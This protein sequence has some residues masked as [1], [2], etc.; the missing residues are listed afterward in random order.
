MDKF[1]LYRS[2]F[3]SFK[4]LCAKGDQPCSFCTYCK[5]YGV[6][7][8]LMPKVL[9]GDFQKIA[10]LPGYR[11]IPAKRPGGIGRLCIRI[12]EDFK[13]LCADGRQPGTFKSYHEGFGVSRSQMHSCLKSRKL[14]VD[15]LPGYNVC[16]ARPAPT[17]GA[18]AQVAFEEVIFEESGFLPAGGGSAIT[19]N[20]GGHVSVSFPAVVD[21]DVVARFVKM[22]AKEADHVGA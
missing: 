9:K 7:P 20:V 14:R 11:H 12:Y 16:V 8:D 3:L 19:V 22:I 15:G 5:E 17:G 13:R 4:E 21:I 18:D 1:E 10:S 6:N 2:V